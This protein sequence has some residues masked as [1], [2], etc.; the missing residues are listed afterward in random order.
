VILRRLK[1]QTF[2]RSEGRLLEW[3]EQLSVEYG[4]NTGEQRLNPFCHTGCGKST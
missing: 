2:H 3:P 4:R 1:I